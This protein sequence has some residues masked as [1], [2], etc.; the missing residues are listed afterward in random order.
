[1]DSDF[2]SRLFSASVDELRGDTLQKYSVVYAGICKDD[3]GID[4]QECMG[5]EEFRMAMPCSVV[6]I[7]FNP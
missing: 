6:V 2:R 3:Y 7:Q 5:V 1:M 4:E